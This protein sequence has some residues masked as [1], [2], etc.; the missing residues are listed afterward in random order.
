MCSPAYFLLFTP[1]RSIYLSLR[2]NGFNLSYLF[3]LPLLLILVIV[4]HYLK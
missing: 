2:L 3:E 1:A 4:T